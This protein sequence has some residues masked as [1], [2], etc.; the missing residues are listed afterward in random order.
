MDDYDCDGPEPY[1]NDLE[2]HELRELDR[3][4]AGEF[5][6]DSPERHPVYIVVSTSPAS[7][8][9]FLGIYQTRQALMGVL[10]EVFEDGTT[11]EAVDL[12]R[13]SGKMREGVEHAYLI[14]RPD[15]MEGKA[16][17]RSYYVLESYGH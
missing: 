3:D 5:S 10:T 9:D 17:T 16:C 14:R 7:G 8:V 6:D 13:I 11:L 1:E 12:D 2:T 4:K 15:P